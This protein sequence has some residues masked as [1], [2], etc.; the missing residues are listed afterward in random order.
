QCVRTFGIQI[1][2]LIDK[3]EKTEKEKDFLIYFHKLTPL[4]TS[5]CLMNKICRIFEKEFDNF[6]IKKFR[7]DIFDYRILKTKKEY[8]KK[9]PILILDEVRLYTDEIK[10]FK[11][12]YNTHRMLKED[13]DDKRNGLKNKFKIRCENICPN[14]EDLCNVIVDLCYTK[15]LNKQ[16]LWDI[17]GKQIIKNLLIRN[18][19]TINLPMED[20]NGDI[21]FCG[22]TFS[23][24]QKRV[25]EDFDC[26]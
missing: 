18:N 21:H 12:E 6:L 9:I 16:F 17:C 7:K 5:D 19:Y 11:S 20:D 10:N 23:M 1:Q 3:P 8:H 14:S 24:M 25:S 22:K 13:M 2:D 15:N 26:E 4:D